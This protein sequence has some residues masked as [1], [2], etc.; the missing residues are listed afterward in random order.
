MKADTDTDTAR[1]LGDGGARPRRGGRPPRSRATP[2]LSRLTLIPLV[3]A[4][5][6]ITPAVFER[7]ALRG[8]V[9]PG[10]D[11]GPVSLAG[12]S[13]RAALAE[14]ETVAGELETTP[15]TATGEG[16]ELSFEP[17]AINYD[18]DAPATV[19]AARRAGRSRNPIADAGGTILRRFRPDRVDLVV[20]WD[21]TLL[22]EVLD[23]WSQQ[24]AD[25]LV[26]GDLEFQGAEVVIVEPQSGFGLER[27]ETERRVE[28]RLRSGDDAPIELPV[29]EADPPVDTAAVER[30]ATR[31]RSILSAPFTVTIDGLPVTL[32]AEQVG[33]AMTATPAGSELELGVDVNLLR[34][35]MAPAIAPFEVAP[36]DASW[37]T[38][39]PLATV[40]PAT[41]GRTVNLQP[42]ADAILQEQRAIVTSTVE[43]PA[44]LTTEA[45][46]ALNITELVS[47][48]TT[49]H[50]AGQARVHNIHRAADI[51]N[52]TLVPPGG[53]F[54]LNDT[55]G[56]RDCANGWVA[57]PAFSTTDGFYEECGGGVSQFSTTLFNATFFGGY[58]DVAHTP[59]T[60]YISRYPMGREATLNYGSIDNRFR[61][62]SNSG[63]LIKTSYT[64]TSITIAYY[65]NLE[66]RVVTAEGPNVL[67]EIPIQTVFADTPLMPAGQQAQ[68][69]GEGGYTGY[70]VEN[71]RIIQRPG[72][73][74]VRERFYWEYD[75]RPITILRGTG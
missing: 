59:H 42:V 29:G 30:A 11:V 31:A 21:D 20:T 56:S 18:V 3:V 65:G 37:N 74:P 41:P 10:V 14:M 9:L 46:Q 8:Q 2:A 13:E 62:N 64:D 69:E 35:Q 48:F 44:A 4:L 12:D 45:A 73:A 17:T 5:L 53:T 63:V 40:V 66:G 19:R 68:A 23:G 38:V 47:E 72:Q 33:A 34:E 27:L 6:L 1:V 22:G 32:A 51:V 15:V 26:N 49:N 71:F 28:A 16:L 58:E 24:L 54:S 7:I 52:N 57:A 75:M 39:G 36:V 50:A 61:N 55:L 60:I 25:D 67:E 70:K 43:L